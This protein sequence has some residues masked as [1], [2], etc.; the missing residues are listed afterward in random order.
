MIRRRTGGRN[1]ALGTASAGSAAALR[2]AIL[3]TVGTLAT[4]RSA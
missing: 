4:V 3:A 2:A 1:R